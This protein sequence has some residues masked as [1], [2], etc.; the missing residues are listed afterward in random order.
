MDH[1]FKIIV[2]LGVL[3]LVWVA[4]RPNFVFLIRI[5]NG[6]VQLAKGK[7]SP[8]FL[9]HVT[10]VC[11]QRDVMHGWIGGVGRGR[12]VR[13]AFSPSIPANCRQQLRNVWA[14]S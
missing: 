1:A 13:L 7:V 14:M 8:E 4:L 10:E 2:I 9:I 5:D 11:R 6:V 12:R 3:A